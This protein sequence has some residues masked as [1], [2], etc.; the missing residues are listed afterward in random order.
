LNPVPIWDIF[1]G[2]DDLYVIPHLEPKTL[3][4]VRAQARNL[5]GV[6]DSSNI[7]ML[8][9]KT[10][11]SVGELTTAGTS[12]AANSHSVMSL[13]AATALAACGRRL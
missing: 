2:N 10:Q 8:Q 9:T 7:I 12:P 4:M 11:E 5:A 13:S 1:S 3:Y 6:S